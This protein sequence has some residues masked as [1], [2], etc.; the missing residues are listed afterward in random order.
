M[1]DRNRWSLTNPPSGT[2]PIEVAAGEFAASFRRWME[3]VEREP[4][5]TPEMVASEADLESSQ[6][7]LCDALFA[8][9]ASPELKDTLLAGTN[10]YANRVECVLKCL[11]KGGPDVDN[12]LRAEVRGG[13]NLFLMAAQLV[14]EKA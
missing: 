3:I 14:A 11:G 6:R 5:P 9:D 13:V 8:L 4:H 2:G 7:V 1:T 10:A 12:N